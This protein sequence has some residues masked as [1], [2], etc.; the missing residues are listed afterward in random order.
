MPYSSSFALIRRNNLRTPHA[1]RPRPESGITMGSIPSVAA[2]PARTHTPLAVITE[3]NTEQQRQRNKI[4][5]QVE[6]LTDIPEITVVDWDSEIAEEQ[7]LSKLD[8]DG[9]DSP[10]QTVDSLTDD[11]VLVDYDCESACPPTPCLE[12]HMPS[13]ADSEISRLDLR[14]VGC[15]SSNGG[16]RATWT[17]PSSEEGAEVKAD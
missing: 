13:D 15:E 17:P 12:P 3:I 7:V 5:A 4:D 14:D 8:G 16:D 6:K 2:V 9:E 11:W 10:P 1:F